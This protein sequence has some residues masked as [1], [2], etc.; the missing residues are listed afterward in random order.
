V[1]EPDTLGVELHRGQRQHYA[2]S[3]ELEKPE[4]VEGEGPGGPSNGWGSA[5]PWSARK[6]YDEGRLFHGPHFQVLRSLLSLSEH[7]G[8]AELTGTGQA[9]WGPGPWLTDPAALDGGMQLVLL[10]AL[11]H[12]QRK[13]LPTRLEALVLHGRPATGLLRCDLQVRQARRHE[14]LADLVLREAAGGRPVAE[15]R[16]LTM[17]LLQSGKEEVH[18]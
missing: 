17:T 10:W 12:R 8:S 5:W 6:A 16:G 13:S 18:A 9:G 14:V 4:R 3:I 15:L 1:G 11:H 7:G 2:A